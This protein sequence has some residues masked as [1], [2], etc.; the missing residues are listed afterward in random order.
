[1]A[2]LI[3]DAG[4]NLPVSHLERGVAVSLCHCLSWCAGTLPPPLRWPVSRQPA[5]IAVGSDDAI[6]QSKRLELFCPL[7]KQHVKITAHHRI[8]PHHAISR[9]SFA[10][11]EDCIDGDSRSPTLD[12]R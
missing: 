8:R 5:S 4:W 7:Q 1:M 6:K 11:Q 2:G 3:V 10:L 9:L 12:D